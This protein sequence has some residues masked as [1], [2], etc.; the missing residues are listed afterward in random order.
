MN[1]SLAAGRQSLIEQM[2][3]AVKADTKA[4]SG[5]IRVPA[6][7]DMQDR[8]NGV[9]AD[10]T[11]SLQMLQANAGVTAVKSGLKKVVGESVVA[12]LILGCL[13]AWVIGAASRRLS[14]P[15]EV[16]EKARI[17]PLVVIP[18]GAGKRLSCNGS[19]NCASSPPRSRCL[20]C[21]SRP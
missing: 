2:Q 13:L 5:A 1:E 17:E 14:S 15:A 8:I 18:A 3:Q 4:T 11:N 9:N 21:P 7:I 6:E 20:I 16:A 10:P 19:G 12:G